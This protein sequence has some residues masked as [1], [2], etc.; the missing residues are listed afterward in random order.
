MKNI[1]RLIAIILLIMTGILFYTQGY[2]NG[3]RE[4]SVRCM[5]ENKDCF[6]KAARTINE[7]QR[8]R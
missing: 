2:R 8:T 1:E 6:E 5:V 7:F 3:V 4:Q